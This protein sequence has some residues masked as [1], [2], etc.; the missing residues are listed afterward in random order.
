MQ[1]EIKR[2]V[3]PALRGR[4]VTSQR[5]E[6][7]LQYLSLALIVVGLSILFSPGRVL[8]Q[9][10]GYRVW[11]DVKIDDSKADT[12]APLSLTVLL[13]NASGGVVGRQ[14]VTNNGRYRFNVIVPPSVADNNLQATTYEIA[15]EGDNGEIAR[16]QIVLNG[17][18]G[19]DI[20]QDFEF[21]W[22][23]RNQAAKQTTGVIS[24]ANAYNRSSANK[25]LFMKAQEAIDGKKYDQA[26]A[27]LKHIIESDKQDFQAWYLLGSIYLALDKLP[28]AEQSYLG[29]V[30]AKPTFTTALLELGKLRAKQKR[31]EEAIDP[32]TRVLETQPQSADA[33][34][35]LG[36]TYLQLKK[37]SKAVPYMNEA[38]RLGRPEAHLRLA[39]LYNAAGLKEK[40]AAEYEEFLKKKP[41]YAERKKLED[42]ISANKKG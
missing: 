12:P 26:V 14:T 23:S 16:V 18:N 7:A 27:P 34:Y 42:Y 28:E 29:A 25:A 40:A 1:A 21:M 36:E 31:F 13:Y 38:A 2:L 3:A 30:E 15:V 17:P 8:A 24:A 37:G 22:K 39:W 35:L 6:S 4:V 41:D 33:N 9:D 19:S 20:R 32:L 11:G 5:P 10:R